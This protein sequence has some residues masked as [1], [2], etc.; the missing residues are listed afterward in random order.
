MRHNHFQRFGR[1]VFNCDTCG[2][3]TREAGQGNDHLCP[4]CWELAGW[5]N[6]VLDGESVESVA[7]VRDQY[8][9]S[10]VAKGGDFAKIRRHF[11]TL[12]D[13]A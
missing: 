5:E 4:Q 9:A 12:W 2:R 11:A 7:K 8:V 3:S 1:G 10:A 6:S 13:G